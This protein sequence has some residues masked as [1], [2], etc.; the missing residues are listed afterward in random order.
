MLPLH[1]QKQSG[2]YS[3]STVMA[4]V[5]TDNRMRLTD[6]LFLFLSTKL[7]EISFSITLIKTI[8]LPPMSTRRPKYSHISSDMA[9]VS[10]RHNIHPCRREMVLCLRFSMHTNLENV[11]STLCFAPMQ[12]PIY[13]LC[14]QKMHGY[15]QC[16]AIIFKERVPFRQRRC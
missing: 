11:L 7:A 16:S 3:G 5:P 2:S 8:Q 4:E 14:L 6:S 15:A 10:Q 12:M 13:C 9:G 1:C